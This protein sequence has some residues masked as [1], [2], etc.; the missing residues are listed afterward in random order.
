R[1]SGSAT[2]SCGATLRGGRRRTE[3]SACA[4]GAGV[5]AL[6]GTALILGESAPD[7]RILAGLERELEAGCHDVTALAHRLRFLDLGD[8]R[9][10][11]PDREEQLGIMLEALGTV[12]PVHRHSLFPGRPAP[13]RGA[14]R[15]EGHP[16][17]GVLGSL[18]L[19]GR[20]GSGCSRDV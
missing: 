9:S 12:A 8:R 19:R 10:G 14:W 17:R 7:A 3:K 20:T 5:P 6:Q 11:V 15:G 16:Q 2:G 18:A 4:S 13:P 1:R